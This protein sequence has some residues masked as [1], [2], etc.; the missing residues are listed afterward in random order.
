MNQSWQLKVW[1]SN[2]AL[3]HPI[4]VPRYQETNFGTETLY[5]N[6]VD[7]S[8]C[9]LLGSRLMLERWSIGNLIWT[10]FIFIFGL[11]LSSFYLKHILLDHIYTPRNSWLLYDFERV[12]I[13]LYAQYFCIISALLIKYTF[14]CHI[15]LLFL[16]YNCFIHR[17]I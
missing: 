7:N 13:V 9:C 14:L 4:E 1:K 6:F 16:C 12:R 10:N 11:F 15:I 3:G 5:L 8:G 17:A 2:W